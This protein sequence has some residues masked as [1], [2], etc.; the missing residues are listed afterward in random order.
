MDENKTKSNKKLVISIVSIILAIAIVFGVILGVK[1]FQ[2]DSDVNGK[3][4]ETGSTIIPGQTATKLATYSDEYCEDGEGWITAE[5]MA[6]VLDAEVEI[7]YYKD[8]LVLQS[9]TADQ[10]TGEE[11]INSY[12]YLTNPAPKVATK[13]TVSLDSFIS[14]STNN[15]YRYYRSITFKFKYD[16]QLKI[17][18]MRYKTKADIDNSKKRTDYSFGIKKI[19]TRD[20]EF[21]HGNKRIT[22]DATS[23]NDWIFEE[24]NPESNFN[25]MYKPNMETDDKVLV[26]RE[27][28]YSS[29]TRTG[30]DAGSSE[31]IYNWIK[32][33]PS[34]LSFKIVRSVF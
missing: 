32:F 5:D 15:N 34:N 31:Y 3:N 4:D 26:C 17:T 7:E 28:D 14:S 6:K 11:T 19:L 33:A 27:N 23:E 24:I 8:R 25:L 20:G 22:I 16:Q 2:K 18:G 1:Y 13:E 9:E 12:G 30:V 10:T 21:C 29:F